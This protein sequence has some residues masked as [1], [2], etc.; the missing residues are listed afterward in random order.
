MAQ[1]KG[2]P[3]RELT[4][5]P[6]GCAKKREQIRATERDEPHTRMRFRQRRP[7]RP[8]PSMNGWMCSKFRCICASH[9]GTSAKRID[10]SATPTP[11]SFARSTQFVSS[12]WTSGN[13]G[14]VIPCANGAISCSR[15]F[16]GPS[17]SLASGCGVT[18]QAPLSATL[19]I[20]RTSCRVMS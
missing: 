8:F 11:K 5:A 15:K 10:P 3:G 6:R 13:D 18:S 7:V 17:L 9:S 1:P 16:P 4:A 14:G 12:A 20:W 2:H 19:W